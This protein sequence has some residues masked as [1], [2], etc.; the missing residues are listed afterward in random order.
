VMRLL[1]V[2]RGEQTARDVMATVMQLARKIGKTAVVSGV[3][4]G[5]IGNRMIKY[6]GRE[7]NLLIEEGATPQQVDRAIED[8]GLAM[9]PFRM[10]D[11]AGNDIG[12]AIR[13]RLYAEN[14]DQRRMVIADRLCELGRYGQKTGKG[15]Y[16]YAA[17]RREALP[18]ADVE[19]V[20]SDCRKA[21]G[22]A[23]RRIDDK[24]IVERCIYALVN[25]GARILEEGIAARASDIDMVYLSGY[26]FPAHR[27]GPMLYADEVGLFKVVRAMRRFAA[28]R[29]DLF[30]RPAALLERLAAEGRR[31]T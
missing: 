25:E 8:F 22:I 24:E 31:L 30:W 19:Q 28:E 29:D 16:R 6:Y 17:G 13:K 2:V 15:W 7:A 18:D 27:G 4:D 12:W 1:E 14:P 23:P 21:A 20:I 26:G 9:G 11:L 10:A 5:F 3:C